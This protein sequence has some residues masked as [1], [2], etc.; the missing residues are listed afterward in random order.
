MG[1]KIFFTFL[2]VIVIVFFG[3]L[4]FEYYTNNKTIQSINRNIIT[5][6]YLNVFDD[7]FYENGTY[8]VK[9]SDIWLS[10]DSSDKLYFKTLFSDPF[11]INGLDS[12]LYCPDFDK[13]HSFINR[14]V[15]LSRGPDNYF[16]NDCDS[17]F[18]K[19]SNESKSEYN[20]YTKINTWPW[21]FIGSFIKKDLL[22]LSR[23]L[24]TF[25]ENQSSYYFDIKN[26]NID[27]TFKRIMK[28]G[29]S[30]NKFLSKE[31]RTNAIEVALPLD[32]VQYSSY[33]DSITFYFKNYLFICKLATV[34]DIENSNDLESIYGILDKVDKEKKVIKLR[35]CTTIPPL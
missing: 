9:L 33:K 28:Y 20:P 10:A 4:I 30:E 6:K 26:Y 3:R 31:K 19:Y 12:Y 27:S 32:S 2:L 22:L 23:D 18:K 35:Y 21:L 17:F 8:P 13:S 15:L 29:Y 7:Y 11:S 16:Q 1:K 5:G 34:N 24:I 25:R 14:F